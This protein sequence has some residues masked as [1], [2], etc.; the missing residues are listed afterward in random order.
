MKKY[1]S[2]LG[3]FLIM[4]LFITGCNSEQ[5]QV[6][7]VE[8]TYWG[9]HA[10]EEAM[11]TL[12]TEYQKTRPY[13]SIDY[14]IFEE[15]V[16]EKN[17][18]NALA[19]DR[20]PDI[21]SLP[22]QDL[23]K[24]ESKIVP[25]PKEL[26]VIRV[27][28]NN[29]PYV[30][31]QKSLT[32]KKA[33]NDFVDII[34]DK[35]ILS[36]EDFNEDGQPV[37]VSDKVFGLPLEMDALVL[38]YNKDLF[39]NSGLTEAP[40]SWSAFLDV[41]KTI[42]RK[43]EANRILQSGAAIGTSNN[44]NYFFDILSALMMQNGTQMVSDNG[45][46][47]FAQ[48]PQGL[49]FPEPPALNAA[50]FYV[51]F[52]STFKESYTWNEKMQNSFNAFIQ[53]RTAM[54]FG[55]AK[56]YDVIKEKAPKLNFVIA[57]IP[58]IQGNRIQ[59][60]AQF[61]FEVVSAK[62]EQQE[63]AWDFIQFMTRIENLTP[64]LETVQ[65]PT[66]LRALVVQQQKDEK[67]GVFAQQLLTARSWYDGDNYDDAIDAFEQLIDDIH[68]GKYEFIQDALN[69]AAGSVAETYFEPESDL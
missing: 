61:N 17:L 29:V 69:A 16:Y 18:L 33:R 39:D 21:F 37:G 46:I 65:K 68:M 54:Y 44:V 55:Y 1:F 20:G 26:E 40:K 9:T 34:F 19:E 57:P 45:A 6:N 42:T 31:P 13:V 14:K 15:D 51:D 23:K 67:L 38:Y 5:V 64:Y 8:L 63:Q 60:I 48:I 2:Q 22:H 28:E 12:I 59:N 36:T 53:G 49:D 50:Q 52:A 27:D 3:I 58:Q 41:V 4:V 11:Q 30:K 66:P 35:M 43:S 47:T 7:P 24:Y 62:S 56:D 25:L 10:N 32:L